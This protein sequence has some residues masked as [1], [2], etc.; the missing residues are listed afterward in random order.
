MSATSAPEPAEWL[1]LAAAPTLAAMALA[2]AVAGGGPMDALCRAGSGWPLDGMALM[3]LLMS[4]FHLSPWLKRMGGR[5]AADDGSI[6]EM[7]EC[8]PRQTL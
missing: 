1:S 3:Y 8:R 4:A 2:T 5:P 7:G 6:E